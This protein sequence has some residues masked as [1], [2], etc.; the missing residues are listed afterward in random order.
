MWEDLLAAEVTLSVANLIVAGAAL[1]L[2]GQGMPL[3]RT[4]LGEAFLGGQS[5][6]MTQLWRLMAV[7][8]RSQPTPRET[9]DVVTGSMEEA[10]TTTTTA[11]V[12]GNK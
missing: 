11:V 10:S 3:R 12:S 1:Y 4:P 8:G 9:N 2:V 7:T 5:P 6:V